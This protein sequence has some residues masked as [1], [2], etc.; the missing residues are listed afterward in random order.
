MKINSKSD[1]NKL[2]F[3]SLYPPVYDKKIPSEIWLSNYIQTYIDRDVR[4]IK[5]IS[6]YML[7]S[8]FIR[9][10]AG[11]TGQ[12]LNFTS[13]S[14]DLGISVNTVKAWISIL[15]TSFIITLLKPYYNNLN[16]RIIKSPKLYFIDTGLVCSLIGVK[17]REQIETHFMKGALFENL[18]I[19]ELLKYFYNNGSEAPIYYW[20]DKLGREIDCLVDTGKGTLALEFKAGTTANISFT[21]NIEYWNSISG[22]SPAHSYIIYGGSKT[23]KNK[24]LTYLPFYELHKIINRF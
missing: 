18:L 20:R 8:K 2:I 22:N 4:Q 19:S 5:N 23:I 10:C 14:N 1:L 15:E 13:I 6:N 3:N 17:E 21:K 12:I 24:E 7:F 16:K 9:I 11:R